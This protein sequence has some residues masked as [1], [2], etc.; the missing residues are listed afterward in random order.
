[1]KR[2]NLKDVRRKY[3]HLLGMTAALVEVVRMAGIFSVFQKKAPARTLRYLSVTLCAALDAFDILSKDGD[4]PY[5]P[6][7]DWMKGTAEEYMDGMESAQKDRV[8][9]Y[10]ESAENLRMEFLE[11]VEVPHE[12]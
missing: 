7:G 11:L 10:L 1:M 5:K 12:N 3:S 4:L 2:N 9:A 8:L 6:I